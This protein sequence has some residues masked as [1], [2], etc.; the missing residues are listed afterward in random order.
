MSPRA[1]PSS[2]N[3]LSPVSTQL[4]PD[5]KQARAETSRPR[6]ARPDDSAEAAPRRLPLG[7]PVSS[8]HLLSHPLLITH[9]VRDHHPIR[10]PAAQCLLDIRKRPS[11]GWRRGPAAEQGRW[12]PGKRR[13]PRAQTAPPGWHTHRGPDARNHLPGCRPV[14]GGGVQQDP[15]GSS[16]RPADTQPGAAGMQSGHRWVRGHG[17]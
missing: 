7:A 5:G 3:S 4:T 17:A 11:L 9:L 8:Q 16:P 12:A 14:E 1:V 2:G 6:R 15:E 13:N 10:M